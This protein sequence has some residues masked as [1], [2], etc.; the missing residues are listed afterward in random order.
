M[1]NHGFEVPMPKVRGSRQAKI[2]RDEGIDVGDAVTLMEEAER[3][4]TY[5]TES[6]KKFAAAA[7]KLL[8]GG[9][10]DDAVSLLI[11]GLMGN[12]GNGKPYPRETILKTL[13]AAARLSEYLK[14]PE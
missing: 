10:T 9:L 11:Q 6:V 14:E 13:R 12:G 1:K 2:L 7:E 4:A 5:L 8:D 3:G